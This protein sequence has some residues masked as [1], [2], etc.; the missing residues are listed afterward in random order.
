MI[1]NFGFQK[2]PLKLPFV[3]C[4]MPVE[5]VQVIVKLPR[6]EFDVSSSKLIVPE[7]GGG[8]GTKKVHKALLWG[9]RFQNYL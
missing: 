9:C 1:F 7:I 2:L 8:A 4:I 6:I 3:I 5:P